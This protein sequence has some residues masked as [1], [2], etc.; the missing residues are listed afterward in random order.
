[1][2]RLHA[3]TSATHSGIGMRIYGVRFNMACCHVPAFYAV[4]EFL[5]K[6]ALPM[7]VSHLFLS[8]D[9][10]SGC[11]CRGTATKTPVGPKVVVVQHDVGNNGRVHLFEAAEGFLAIPDLTIEPLLDVVALLIP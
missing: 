4:V 2:S 8:V 11:L 10:D 5:P 3:A 9:P 7:T 6:A 1:M